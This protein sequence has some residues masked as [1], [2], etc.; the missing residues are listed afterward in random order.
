MSSEGDT[1]YYRITSQTEPYTVAVARCRDSV[2][3]NLP[4]PEFA[5]QVGQPGFLYPVY[6]YD[7]LV[8]IPPEVFHEGVTYTVTSVD[9]EAFY[10]Q[11]KLRTV[12]LP[13]TVTIVDSG[14]FH[15]SSLQNV[16]MSDNVKSI[17]SYAFS[18]TPLS[19]IDLPDSLMHIGDQAFASTSINHLEIPSKVKVLSHQAFYNCPL[20]EITFH[21]GLQEIQDEA[22]SV[23]NVDTLVFPSTLRKIGRLIDYVENEV[24]CRYVEF[25]QGDEPLELGDNCFINFVNLNTAIL[26]DNL[27]RLGVACFA[28]T[29]L[30][31]ITIPSLIDTIPSRC[32]ANCRLLGKVDLPFGLSVIG[33]RAFTETPLLEKITIPATLTAIGDKAFKTLSLGGMKE[34]D[35]YCETPP[36]IGD[37]AFDKQDSI[38]IRVPC[39]KIPTYISAPIWNNYTNFR[40]EDCVGTMEYEIL[41]LRVFPNPVVNILHIEYDSSQPSVCVNITDLNGHCVMARTFQTES[42]TININLSSLNNGIYLLTLSEK[43]GEI[44]FHQKI[45]KYKS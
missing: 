32:F 8:T 37:A 33:D 11:K 6:D 16:I 38:L 29:A 18:N 9:K 1:L 10:M 22:L 21:E 23:E 25:K 36:I 7:T 4:A 35:I 12:I 5:W 45:I 41:N 31:Q 43:N 17:N 13:E 24:S 42:S 40:Y 39:G 34:V 14:A 19:S 2:Y 30:R 15:R 27:V 3:H 28:Y 44:V 26:P 20:T